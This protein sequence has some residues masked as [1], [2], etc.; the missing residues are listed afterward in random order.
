[1]GQWRYSLMHDKLT[2]TVQIAQR[3]Y[4]LAREQNNPAGM[5]GAC[6]ALAMTHHFLGDFEAGRRHAIHGIQI[7]RSG[8]VQSHAED[9]DVRAATC[10]C[11]E[12]FSA[13]NFGEIVGSQRNMVE[14]IS[15]AKELN[16]M[17]GLAST[18]YYAASFAYHE[19]NPAEVERLASDVIELSTRHHFA[20]WL[21][22]GSILRGWARSASGDTVEC[23]SWIEDG[24]RDYRATGANIGVTYLL[25][26]KAEALH[27]A[28]RIIHLKLLR[29]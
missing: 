2:A 18:L 23:I 5:V 19:R 13:W 15:L 1:M 27:L 21:A 8:S 22:I 24:I 25:G 9:L 29:H 16:D 3:V 26:M 20:H 10:L 4:S 12:A 11:Y 14:A 28:G 6:S 7:W 17:H